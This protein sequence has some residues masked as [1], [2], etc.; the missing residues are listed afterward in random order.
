MQYLYD[1]QGKRY[2]DLIGGIA[3]IS[4]GHSHPAITKAASEQIGKLQHTSQIYF[5]EWQG[6]Y[7]KR[8]CQE[9]GDGFDSVY[10]CNS[11]G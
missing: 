6:E 1:Y 9:L 3:T 2:I 5:N 8:L 10:L 11:G 4:V 7:S